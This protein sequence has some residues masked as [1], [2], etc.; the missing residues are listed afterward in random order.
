METSFN[1]QKGIGPDKWKEISFHKIRKLHQHIEN[2]E[3]APWHPQRIEDTLV[4]KEICASLSNQEALRHSRA[5]RGIVLCLQESI[6]QNNEEIKKLQSLKQSYEKYLYNIKIDQTINL[7]SKV[8]RNKRPQNEKQVENSSSISILSTSHFRSP[9]A[10][11]T[12][13]R[14]NRRNLSTSNIIC[15]WL[16]RRS[17]NICWWVWSGVLVLLV[18]IAFQSINQ[19]RKQLITIQKERNRVLDLLCQ[20]GSV[21]QDSRLLTRGPSRNS[22]GFHMIFGNAGSNIRWGGFKLG[23]GWC[24]L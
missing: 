2:I 19:S 20:R 3:N 9:M 4:N 15:R 13:W 8:I 23:K 10:P 21:V 7:E 16:W 5:V 14:S 24:L 11:T 1:S 22:V 18:I 17:R 6:V 12:Y